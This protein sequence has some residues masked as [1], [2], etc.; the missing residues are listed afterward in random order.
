LL[1]ELHLVTI[2]GAL[3]IA[4]E[5]VHLRRY[6][7]L[8]GDFSLETLMEPRDRRWLAGLCSCLWPGWPWR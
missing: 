4:M 3:V 2:V 5:L 1:L 7:M 8:C 6:G